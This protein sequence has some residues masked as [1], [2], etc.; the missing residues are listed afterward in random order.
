MCL[1][2]D[3]SD[4]NLADPN[5]SVAWNLKYNLDDTG[6]S[7]YI[8]DQA[9]FALFCTEWLWE[10]CWRDNYIEMYG[11]MG[12]GGES[13]MMGESFAVDSTQA[14]VPEKS[15]AEQFEDAK[16]LIEKVEEIWEDP[17]VQ[18]QIGEKDWL[19]FMEKVY[20]WLG[21]LEI[22]AEDKYGY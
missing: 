11:M 2:H 4:P 20:D 7:A 12:G 19:E 22:L 13:M 15:I 21:E 17:L 10:A 6:S 1:S 5:D 14:A 18:E 9:D 8:I 16:R 3:P